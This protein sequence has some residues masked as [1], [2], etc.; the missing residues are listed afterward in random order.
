MLFEATEINGMSLPNR[1]V[2]SATY[3][4]LAADDGAS[5]AG[6]TKM[7]VELVRGGVGLIIA[8]HSFVHTSGRA[9]PWQLGMHDDSLIDGHQK[10]TREVHQAGGKIAAQ[11]AHAGAM[12]NPEVTGQEAL[13]PS[14]MSSSQMDLVVEAFGQAAGR[15][16]LS[17]FD[18]V[19]IHSAHGYLLSQS[20][21]P[22]FNSRSDDYGGSIENRSRLLGRVLESIRT[23]V[24]PDYP[25]MIKMNCEDFLKGG[26]TRE[27]SLEVAGMLQEKGID[28]IEVSG[29]TVL[30]M[31]L[32]PSRFGIQTED[33]EAYF[34]EQAR[35]FKEKLDIPIIL[36]GGIRSFTLAERLVSEG[37]ADYLS[38]S[39][40]LIREPALI[41]RWKNGDTARAACLS[42]NLCFGPAVQGKGIYCVVERESV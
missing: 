10:M 15:A 34:R 24:G 8:G 25:V 31:N 38:I 40:P 21:S 3:E 20:L 1:F 16:K 19:Q 7:L 18:A 29:G 9:G 13:D 42:D 11:L 26:L 12:V 36:V 30:S 37:F 17:G 6:L 32:S 39:R 28:A 22:Y 23:A 41:N 14:K 4:G 5:T 27:D 35:E 33:K 2:R